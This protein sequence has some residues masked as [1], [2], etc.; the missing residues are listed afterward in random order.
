MNDNA[1]W[2]LGSEITFVLL[3]GIQIQR[4]S[5]TKPSLHTYVVDFALPFAANTVS[6]FQN[7]LVTKA[8]RIYAVF[9]RK[10]SKS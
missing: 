5:N 6:F 4:I 7:G 2:L 10:R 1:F 9:Q 3:K 8:A